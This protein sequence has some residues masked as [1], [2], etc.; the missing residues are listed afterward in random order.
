[1][2]AKVV[3]VHILIYL[4][5]TGSSMPRRMGSRK[6]MSFILRNAIVDCQRINTK[7]TVK[8]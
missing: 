1:L 4:D 6:L 5:V 7:K 2:T 3:V 8:Y